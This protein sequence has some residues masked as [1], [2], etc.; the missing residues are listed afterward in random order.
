[1]SGSV[2]RSR[3]QGMLGRTCQASPLLVGLLQPL[4]CLT[5]AHM[6]ARCCFWARFSI[7]LFHTLQEA[8]TEWSPVTVSYSM[9]NM[10]HTG[11]LDCLPKTINANRMSRLTYTAAAAV[12]ALHVDKQGIVLLCHEQKLGSLKLAG[13][14]G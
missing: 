3:Q 8:P 10:L 2:H 1:M 11:P 6:L 9:S 12:K 7:L 5:L 14:F 4:V 13:M